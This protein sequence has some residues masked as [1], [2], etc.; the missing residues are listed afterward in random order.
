[1]IVF[2]WILWSI[3]ILTFFIQFAIILGGCF[4]LND[5]TKEVH[6]RVNIIDLLIN[7]AVFVF[8]TLYLFL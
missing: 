8:L 5:P 1:M 3:Y 7:I 4:A 2:A 6:L